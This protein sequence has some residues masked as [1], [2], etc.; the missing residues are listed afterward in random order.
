MN[1]K[2]ISKEFRPG[3]MINKPHILILP[4]PSLSPYV[5]VYFSQENYA[6][7]QLSPVV[8]LYLYNSAKQKYTT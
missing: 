1:F 7:M 5:Y 4:L 8:K 6:K 2:E 3:N